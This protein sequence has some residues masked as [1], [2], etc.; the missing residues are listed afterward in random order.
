MALG[1][2]SFA[3]DLASF[4]S[5]EHGRS[6]SSWLAPVLARPG[7]GSLPPSLEDE[8]GYPSRGG[9]STGSLRGG[10]TRQTPRCAQMLILPGLKRR[11]AIRV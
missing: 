1:E 2:V 11:A 3:N 10:Q 4:H 6:I 8:R 7:P 9:P 5:T